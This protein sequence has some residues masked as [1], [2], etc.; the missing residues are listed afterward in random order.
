M[1]KCNICEGNSGETWSYEGHFSL[2]ANF[3]V[4]FASDFILWILCQS[5]QY[6][7]LALCAGDRLCHPAAP[8]ARQCQAIFSSSEQLMALLSISLWWA[9]LELTSLLTLLDTQHQENRVPLN[10]NPGK[11]KDCWVPEVVAV[12]LRGNADVDVDTNSED[13]TLGCKMCTRM[14]T[15]WVALL[16]MMGL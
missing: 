5:L 15:P 8:S 2:R 9:A 10:W 4:V 6:A 1:K 3:S 16:P 14:P 12:S 7:L 13:T 11:S